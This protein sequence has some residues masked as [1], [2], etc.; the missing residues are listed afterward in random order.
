MQP[1][2]TASMLFNTWRRAWVVC[3]T[4]GGSVLDN[5]TISSQTWSDFRSSNDLEYRLGYDLVTVALAERVQLMR[6][7]RLCSSNMTS[8][9]NN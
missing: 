7:R 3:L 2:P 6:M 8:K 9:I 5:L 1:W 4:R